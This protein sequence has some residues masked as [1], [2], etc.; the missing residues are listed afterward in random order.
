MREIESLS[1]GFR[2]KY[3]SYEELSKQVKAWAEAYPD[4]VR[5]ESIGQSPEGRD[6]WLL[7]IG[8]EPDR[9]RPAAWVDGNIHAGEYTGSS[10]ALGIA[11]DAIRIHV[12][13]HPS[14]DLPP[15]LIEL[16]RRDVLL[17]VLPRMCP[18]GVEEVMQ[19]SRF[20][21]SNLRD[22]RAGHSEPYWRAHDVDGDG[23]SRLM[24]R[25]DPT[26]DFVAS[27]EFPDLMLPRRIEDPGPYYS[28][29]PEGTIEHWDGFTVPSPSIMSDMQTDLNRNFPAG[30]RGEPI[31]LGAGAYP[32]SEPESRAVTE[33]ATK[34]PNIFAWMALH[35]FGGVYI[36][37]HG[38][39]PDKKM[40]QDD[41]ALYHQL[42]EWAEA[43]SGYPMVSGFEE[44]TY[45]PDKGLCGDL[46][47]FAYTE[48]GAVSFVVELWDF[49]KQ[50]G[51]EVIRPFVFNYQR[52]TRQDCIRIAEWDRDHNE[53]RIV[54]SWK[55]MDHPQLGPIEV[56]GY[57]PRVG[58]WNPPPD[59][60]PET[61]TAQ[62]QFFLR[63]ASLAPR[64]GVSVEV[65]SLEGGLRRVRAT[66]ENLGYL[67][68]YV[69]SSAKALPH[70]DSLHVTLEL[71]YEVTLLSGETRADIGHL[72]GWGGY[73][74]WHSP[75]LARSAGAPMRKRLEWVVRGQGTVR[76]VAASARV[77][78]AVGEAVVG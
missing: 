62:S 20:V 33:F 69:L 36:R 1:T 70:S 74:K 46:A 60:L 39:L 78:T 72:E 40:D 55:P 76:V 17:Y 41:L 42:E 30:W 27:T 49:F 18:D 25:E 16:L 15:H 32:T 34:H 7:T 61:C 71:D 45:E 10:V 52:R 59:R 47:Q 26:G 66:V 53:G 14:V 6:L 77:G 65:E 23:Q 31:Q 63:L 64:V 28:L 4:V 37:Q 12:E 21:R 38:D 13:E 8:P 58:I 50:A 48:R 19:T 56:G 67:P 51:L 73:R 54:G 22:A 57:D 5:L 29:Y 11:E 44:F 9:I 3:L 24:R 43:F 68:T 75:I 35:T 2:S